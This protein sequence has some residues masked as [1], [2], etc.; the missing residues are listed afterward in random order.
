M[1]DENTCECELVAQGKYGSI[2]VCH[3]CSLYHLHIGPISFRLER[4]MFDDVCEMIMCAF[5]RRDSKLERCSTLTQ[6]H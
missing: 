2:T 1:K 6:K 3:K 5:L 4:E